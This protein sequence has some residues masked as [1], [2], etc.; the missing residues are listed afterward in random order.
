MSVDALLA[1]IS[2]NDV[3]L[4]VRLTKLKSLSVAIANAESIESSVR[5]ARNPRGRSLRFVNCAMKD[6]DEFQD[7]NSKNVAKTFGKTERD[8]SNVGNQRPHWQNISKYHQESNQARQHQTHFPNRGSHY[9]NASV[10]D[11]K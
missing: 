1:A 6:E 5:Q 8:P 4:Q 3:M 10:N 9:N 2:D 11:W 7:K